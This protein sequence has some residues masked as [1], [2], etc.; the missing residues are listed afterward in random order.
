MSPPNGRGSRDA[1]LGESSDSRSGW[2]AHNRSFKTPDPRNR[3]CHQRFV[4]QY[5]SYWVAAAYVAATVAFGDSGRS[6]VCVIRR[7][8]ETEEQ[9]DIAGS[10]LAERLGDRIRHFVAYF[11]CGC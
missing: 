9:D 3:L 11:L 6:A 8:A 10:M 4:G 2:I 7:F 1:P 5:L